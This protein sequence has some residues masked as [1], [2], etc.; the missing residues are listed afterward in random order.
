MQ[1]LKATFRQVATGPDA[2]GLWLPVD[3]HFGL[4]RSYQRVLEA[5]LL[6]EHQVGERHIAFQLT[7]TVL[8]HISVIIDFKKVQLNGGKKAKK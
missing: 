8:L 2:T 7:A 3:F 5:P 6:L 4:Y 1:L